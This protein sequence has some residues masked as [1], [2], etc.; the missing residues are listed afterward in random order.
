[1]I[2]GYAR[3]TGFKVLILGNNV[4]ANIEVTLVVLFE[5]LVNGLMHT[6]DNAKTSVAGF[7]ALPIGSNALITGEMR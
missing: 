7:K 2:G 5:P 4:P 1:M 6:I 3:V